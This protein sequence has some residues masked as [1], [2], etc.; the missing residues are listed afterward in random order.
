MD[1]YTYNSYVGTYILKQGTFLYN[2]IEN[3]H[4]FFFVA[5]NY[6]SSL[7]SFVINLNNSSPLAE[8]FAFRFLKITVTSK[9]QT[10]KYSF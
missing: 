7:F 4:N 3:T 10:K 1:H 5:E 9:K 8:S 2:K 6:I